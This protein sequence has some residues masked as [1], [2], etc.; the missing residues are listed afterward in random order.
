MG[1]KTEPGK[2]CD[3]EFVFVQKDEFSDPFYIFMIDGEGYGRISWN[4]RDGFWNGSLRDDFQ[5]SSSTFEAMSKKID[6]LNEA[7]IEQRR[8]FFAFLNE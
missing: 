3:I 5:Y 8:R 7:L 6:E 2:L 1:K 4:E